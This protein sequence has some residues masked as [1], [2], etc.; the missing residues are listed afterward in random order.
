[1]CKRLAAVVCSSE[2]VLSQPRESLQSLRRI[3]SERR[4]NPEEFSWP[5]CDDPDL[6]LS[7]GHP[8]NSLKQYEAPF[9]VGPGRAALHRDVSAQRIGKQDVARMRDCRRSPSD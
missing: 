4:C 6:V 3:T 5:D 9:A 1:M 8:G 2:Q 7:L